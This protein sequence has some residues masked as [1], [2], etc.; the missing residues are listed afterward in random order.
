MD[1]LDLSPLADEGRHVEVFLR[2]RGR[3]LRQHAHG[4]VLRGGHGYRAFRRDAGHGHAGRRSGCGWHKSTACAGDALRLGIQRALAALRIVG[5]EAGGDDLSTR[6][7]VKQKG[8]WKEVASQS[9]RFP[10]TQ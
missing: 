8:I 9:T 5:L 2:E 6:I 3:H 7:F 4:V 10:L 1:L